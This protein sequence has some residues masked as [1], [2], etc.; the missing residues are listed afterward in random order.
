MARDGHGHGVGGLGGQL[1]GEAGAAPLGHLQRGGGEHQAGRVVIRDGHCNVSRQVVAA[2]GGGCTE[3]LQ[4]V[5]GVAVLARRYGHGLGFVPGGRGEGETGLA[6]GQILNGLCVRL[7]GQHPQQG[8]REHHIRRGVH[9]L[10]DVHGHGAGGLG[11]QLHGVA[12][13]APFAQPQ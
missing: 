12:G 8:G 7:V 10:A 9:I 3:R 2:A 5:G 11:G 4:L 6:Q 13:V 1:Y